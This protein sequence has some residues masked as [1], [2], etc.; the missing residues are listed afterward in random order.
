MADGIR[1]GDDAVIDDKKG[2]FPFWVALN[3]VDI[4]FFFAGQAVLL[5]I[6]FF[7]MAAGRT[8]RSGTGSICPI[9]RR[10]SCCWRRQ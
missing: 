2:A 5:I 3:L 9:P 8:R 4:Y 10:G 1:Q 6:Y 7:C